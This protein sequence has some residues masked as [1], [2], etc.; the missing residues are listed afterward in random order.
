MS[1]FQGNRVI[2]FCGRRACCAFAFLYTWKDLNADITVIIELV[3]VME[4]IIFKY[5]DIFGIIC[6][7]E[8]A[9]TKM[10]ARLKH[11]AN[12]MDGCNQKILEFSVLITPNFKRLTHMMRWSRWSTI[13]IGVYKIHIHL[14]Y[15]KLCIRYPLWIIITCNT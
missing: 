13:V 1:M 5:M 2:A 15:N 3:T 12:M 9:S 7:L 14:K 10:A 8:A 4:M 11:N 6:N